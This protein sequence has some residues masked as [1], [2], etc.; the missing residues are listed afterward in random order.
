MQSMSTDD[1]RALVQRELQADSWFAEPVSSAL[2]PAGTYREI[3]QITALERTVDSPLSDA[4][5]L[6]IS[7]NGNGHR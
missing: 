3:P 2:P 4:P 5:E 7:P 1:W 6:V